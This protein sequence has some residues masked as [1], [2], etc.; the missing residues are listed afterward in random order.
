MS[1]RTWNIAAWMT[2]APVM[3][4]GIVLWIAFTVVVVF[5]LVS[6]IADIW[7]SGVNASDLWKKVALL[8]IFVRVI[9]TGRHVRKLQE[10]IDQVRMSVFATVSYLDIEFRNRRIDLPPGFGA[11]M[12]DDLRAG[13]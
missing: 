4:M 12:K 9:L 7:D 6:A 1:E 2:M 5:V 10:N 13:F 8:A 3:L 11:R